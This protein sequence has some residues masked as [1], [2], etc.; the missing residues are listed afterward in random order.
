MRL[1]TVLPEIIQEEQSTFIKGRLITDNVIVA[2]E[3][4]TNLVLINGMQHGAITLSKRLHQGDPI[5]L[6][7]FLICLERPSSLIRKGSPSV[8]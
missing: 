8:G 1:Q 2:Y 6:Y 5:S 3:L 7:L 4:P